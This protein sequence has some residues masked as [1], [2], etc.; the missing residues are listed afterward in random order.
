[1]NRPQSKLKIKKI[2]TAFLLLADRLLVDE[3]EVYI[4]RM[5]WL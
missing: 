1:L 4:W 3:A 2:D 5:F